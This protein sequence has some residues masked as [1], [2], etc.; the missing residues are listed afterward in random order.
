M[1][2]RPYADSDWDAIRNIYDLS[3]PD[4]M[5]G[6]VDIAAVI[7]LDQ[8]AAALALFRDSVILVA[9]D[10]E[11]VTGFSGYKGNDISWLFVHPAHV[12]RRSRSALLKEILGRLQGLI[13]L[14]VGTSNQAARKLYSRLGFIIAR[15]FTGKLN[16]HDVGALTL[17]Y[18][19]AAR[20]SFGT[21]AGHARCHGPELRLR[22]TI[23]E[24]ANR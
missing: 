24:G 10:A 21:C 11:Q 14:N 4:E 23:M 13:T 15:E 6:S 7:P 16:G 5:R 9:D 19:H 18:E 3:K 17:R 12:V 20:G 8:D 1:N 22:E 2:I